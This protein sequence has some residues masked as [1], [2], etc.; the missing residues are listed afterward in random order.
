VSPLKWLLQAVAWLPEP[1]RPG[2]FLALMVIVL[3]FVLVQRGLVPVWRGTV[4]GLA[5]L[6]DGIVGVVLRLE[7]TIT[8]A[9]RRRGKAATR[10]ALVLGEATDAILDHA[11]SLHERH[12][13]KAVAWKR[14]PW[15]RCMAILLLCTGAWV[16]M[17]HLSVSSIAK[18]RLAQAF[19]PWRDLEAWADADSRRGASPRVL[20]THR[21]RSVMSVRVRCRSGGR[22]RGWIVLRSRSGAFVS[23]RY[24]QM[25]TGTRIV[26]LRLSR[27]E[28]RISRG[29][30]VVVELA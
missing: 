28:A 19:A 10:W 16:T 29:G 7:F 26:R 5:R 25:A 12:E 17:E 8:A 14:P 21:R 22:C 24:L 3:W 18:Y 23:S 30:R 2:V 11:A 6:I 27:D 15:K 4:R 9:W 13:H 20:W 1:V